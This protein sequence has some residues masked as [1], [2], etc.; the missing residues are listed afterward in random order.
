M[1]YVREPSVTFDKKK[2][3]SFFRDSLR[4][5]ADQTLLSKFN[6]LC[7]TSQKHR[8]CTQ[9]CSTMRAND[10]YLE[11]QNCIVGLRNSSLLGKWESPGSNDEVQLVRVLLLLI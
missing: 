8:L 4:W 1:R 2:E 7:V 3:Q 5:I 10:D 11:A 9:Y 6:P